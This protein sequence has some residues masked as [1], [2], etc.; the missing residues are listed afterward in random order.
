MPLCE[1]LTGA[2]GAPPPTPP[3][4]P[5]PSALLLVVRVAEL[6]GVG[7]RVNESAFVGPAFLLCFLVTE[8]LPAR[9]PED[10]LCLGPPALPAEGPGV[11]VVPRT[12]LPEP[13][14]RNHTLEAARG[15]R[16]RGT[17]GSPLLLRLLRLL[18]LRFGGRGRLGFL[19]R[20]LLLVRLGLLPLLA[21]LLLLFLLL[22]V[23]LGLS[24]GGLLLRLLLGLGGLLLLLRLV[25]LRLLLGLGGL[26]LL[27]RLVLLGILVSLLLV[28]LGILLRFLLGILL[29]FLLS[30]LAGLGV[31]RELME[32]IHGYNGGIKIQM[33]RYHELTMILLLMDDEIRPRRS[34]V[35]APSSR[36]TS[37][38]AGS[39]TS[40]SS[41]FSDFE[42]FA[43][44]T[45]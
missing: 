45:K 16:A 10:L 14:L 9:L 4:T 8:P 32:S 31:L 30:L 1:R 24:L 28:L 5:H 21:L 22:L 23:F 26:L 18:R 25:L 19:R 3:L 38:P 2:V 42:R 36:T 43:M 29:R 6:D 17:R 33:E 20:W 39:C 27:L 37:T 40:G 35:P 7:P 41:D 44:L 11:A 13:L 34:A 12:L 15:R